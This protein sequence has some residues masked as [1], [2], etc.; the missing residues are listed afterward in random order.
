[1]RDSMADGVDDARLGSAIRSLLVAERPA[2]GAPEALRASVLAIPTARVGWRR[3]V[4]RWRPAAA[5]AALATVG[6]AAFALWSGRGGPFAPSGAG[7]GTPQPFD[8]TIEG[9]GILYGQAPVLGIV[10][11]VLL[12]A[13]GVVVARAVL[14]WRAARRRADLALG[15]GALI[16]AALVLGVALE[17]GFAWANSYGGIVGFAEIQQPLPGSDGVP[18]L[19]ENVG[20]RQP[21]VVVFDLRN[22]GPLPLELRGVVEDPN[23]PDMVSSRWTAVWLGRNSNVIGLAT[24]AAPFAPRTIEPGETVVVYLVG[25]SG[26]CA[27]GPGYSGASDV[28]GYT[29][30]GRQLRIAYGVFGLAA[31]SEITLPVQVVEPVRNGPCPP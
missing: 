10:A 19:Y 2:A 1:M 22:P 23:A 4:V 25:L 15:G 27:Y 28:G 16:A 20:P 14:R 21:F 7:Q 12:L 13:C 8:P 29:N 3:L 11:G 24:D 5:A 31:S 17:P 26:E 9:P 6:V 30:R 18:V